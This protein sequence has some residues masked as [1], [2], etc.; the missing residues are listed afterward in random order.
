MSLCTPDSASLRRP[1][2]AAARVRHSRP[3]NVPENASPR[4]AGRGLRKDRHYGFRAEIC[5]LV[6][7]YCTAAAG[8][9]EVRRGRLRAAARHDVVLSP[10]AGRAS[11]LVHRGEALQRRLQRLLV[12]HSSPVSWALRAARSRPTRRRARECELCLE[13]FARSAGVLCDHPWTSVTSTVLR[14]GGGAW[15]AAACLCEC[16]KNE[17]SWAAVSSP[18]NRSATSARYTR[19][20]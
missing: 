11:V 2:A 6:Y 10:R 1:A 8:I 5:E 12:E 4:G 14:P 20:G 16:T 9:R 3:C 19:P 7:E 13:E 15:P 17:C 18:R